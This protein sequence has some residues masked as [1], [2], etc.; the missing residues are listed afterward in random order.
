MARVA[1]LLCLAFAARAQSV[2]I[3]FTNSV[4]RAPIV[5]LTVTLKGPAEYTATTD[6]AGV[7]RIP[8]AEPGYYRV[9]FKVSGFMPAPKSGQPV[10]V[11]DEPVRLAWEMTPMCKLHGR[12]LFPDGAPVKSAQVMLF[13]Y[14]RG[15]GS[16]TRTDGD[17]R[18][19]I[20]GIAAGRFTLAA[21]PP[22]GAKS[23][24][25]ESWAPTYFPN[26]ADRAAAQ[27]IVLRPGA[28]VT[29]YEIR[30]RSVP[31]RRIR[32]IVRDDLGKPVPGAALQLINSGDGLPGQ[33]KIVTG[34]DGAF[35][36][37]VR[38]GEW[39]LVGSVTREGVE[40][41][42]VEPVTVARR[43]LDH[44]DVRL[45][46]P[47]T[48]HGFVDRDEPRDAEGNRQVTAVTLI[49]EPSRPELQVLK[50]HEQDGSVEL[51]NVYPGRYEIMPLGF[52]PGYYLDS[53]KLGDREVLGQKVDLFEGVALAR[54]V[55]KSGAPTVRA[56]VEKGDGVFVVLVPQD[57][58][59]MTDQFIRRATVA[60]GRCEIGSLRPGD[61]YAFA[62]DRIDMAALEDP[63]FVRTLVPRAEKV[64]VDKGETASVSLK[65]T[66]WP[67]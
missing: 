34:E 5:D 22:Q 30:L 32:G 13:L 3:T 7:A 1:L 57:D 65:V 50:F 19:T 31:V 36:E 55:Y 14:R 8:N 41:K 18:F 53:V 40:L 21:S 64:H 25:G 38:M 56:Q 47:F 60:D 62:F 24:E 63:F 42:G 16:I 44:I 45:A 26:A 2:E 23:V 10:H 59:L 49:P 52:R 33:R 12:V 27:P 43:D 20:Q 58:A 54:V 61:Y 46:R 51:K 29:G 6:G 35:D 17:G 15:G 37:E 39:R 67:E 48:L 4:T 28:D 66:P 9:G 11:A